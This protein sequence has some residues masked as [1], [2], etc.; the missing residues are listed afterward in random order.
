MKY[1]LYLGKISGVKISIH[2]TFL[3]LIVWVIISNMRA[4]LGINDIFWSIAFVLAVFLCVTLHELGHALTAQRFNIKTRN[5]TLLPIGGLAEMESIPED[6]KQELLVA[7]AGPAV[8]LVIAA[9]LFPLSGGTEVL[10]D[11][12]NFQ[13]LGPVN[14]LPLLM[15]INVWLAIFNLI[16]AFPM[17]GGRVFRALLSFKIDRARATR[18]AASVG[19]VLA[20]LFALIGFFI[21]PFLI[22]IALFIFL[23]AQ[24]EVQFYEAK[25]L[26]H[27]YT[28]GDVLMKE[29]PKMDVKD[30]L[31]DA[32]QKLLKG[33]NR[34]FVVFNDG[35][36]VGTITKNEILRALQLKEENTMV[37]E[38]MNPELFYVQSDMEL[39]VAWNKMKQ[40]KSP[41]MVVGTDGH[42]HGMVDEENLI[43]FIQIR[44]ALARAS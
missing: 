8:N 14:F 22:F 28:V 21:N 9:V 23:G 6:P 42:V 38:L 43:E 11:M 5:I 12:N 2:W 4:G 16:P 7:F 36:V 31:R 41:I 26:L 35:K 37:E 40:Q 29:V 13:R 30:S 39:D 17:D 24:A 34:N 19:Q 25:A 1:S 18:V 32:A 10:S 15:T 3:I 20:I 33:Q 44:N 27:G